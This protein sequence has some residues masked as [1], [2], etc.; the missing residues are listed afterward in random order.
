MKV[1]SRIQQALEEKRP[2]WSFEYFPPKTDEGVENLFE[3]IQR[4]SGLNPEFI[5]V[6]WGAGGSTSDRTLEICTTAQAYQ[7]LE[8]CMH[9]TC[10]NMTKSKIDFA[11][12]EAKAA[13][14][15]NILALRGDPP[16]NHEYANEC[17]T[18][19]RYAFDLVSYIR[20]EHGDYFCIGV[21]GYPEGQP[22]SESKE[23]DLEYLKLKV[24]AGSDFVMS[25]I[26][27][28][29]QLFLRFVEDCRAIGI[30]VPILP[31]IMPIQT[32]TSFR[33]LTNLCQIEVPTQILETLESIKHDDQAVKEY[34]VKLCIEMI[35]ELRKGGVNGFHFCTLNLE[36]S[37][38][39]IL[40][41]CGFVS[42]QLTKIDGLPK[43]ANGHT[44]PIQPT[45][46]EGI[47]MQNES[48]DEFPNGRWGDSRSPAYGEMDGYG[49]SLKVTMQ[50]AIAL[51]GYPVDND[52]IS[53][54][55]SKYIQGQLKALPWSDEPLFAETNAIGEK[56][57]D[58][59]SKGYWT[60]G[61]QPAV[62][63]V[64]SND[65]VFGWGPKNG[66]IYQKA[67]LEFFTS[68]EKLAE[69]LAKAASN[70]FITF[71]A[72][73]TKGDFKTNV[74]LEEPNAVTWGVF[75][76]RE[77]AQ[78][79]VI[80]RGSFEAW[81]EEAFQIWNEWKMIYP[82][83]SPS[84]KLIQEIGDTYYLVNIVHNDFQNADAIFA[85]FQ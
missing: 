81:A 4:M 57:A 47:I 38:R 9:L 26:F 39:L 79:T 55:F 11:L 69:L 7:N 85:L 18:Q 48:W 27:F 45:V 33:R 71:Y 65:P 64:R 43:Q 60:V 66:Y 40:E 36:R 3:R 13:G 70:P 20:Q 2:F 53:A 29:P 73:N 12:K 62:N 42:K 58:L 76:S 6:T 68:P 1:T 21:A 10:T 75:P 84:A 72:Q 49:A 61:S 30:T 5:D 41:G 35:Q 83:Q 50:E 67:F 23:K 78:P 82:P 16:R 46:L 14:I 19:F 51:W 34:G 28:D 25:Q 31:G 52:D 56:L 22:E 54:L 37:V 59:N 32:Y 44:A 15:Q 77:I 63:G 74:E 8:T 24:D 80:E 17:E